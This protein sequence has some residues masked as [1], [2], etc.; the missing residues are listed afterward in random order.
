MPDVA[1][2]TIDV[3]LLGPLEVTRR[4]EAVPLGSAK[5]RV[6]LTVLAAHQGHW[7]SVE[8]LVDAAWGESAAAGARRSLQTHVSNLRG[9]LDPDRVGVLEGG[10]G[11][12]RLAAPPV[13]ETD[14]RRFEQLADAS[15]SRRLEAAID[16]WRGDPFSDVH[17]VGLGPIAVS[18][19]E[20]YLSVV[21]AWAAA[22]LRE[23]DP[24]RAVPRL[25]QLVEAHPLRESLWAALIRCL[26]A[27]GRNADALA[28]FRRLADHLAETGLEPSPGLRDLEE[29]VFLED[30]SLVVPG[31]DRFRL[32]TVDGSLH[33][34]AD[35]VEEVAE[36]L[37]R[38]RLVTLTGV[39][40]IGKTRL[41]LAAGRVRSGEAVFV[42][43]SPVDAEGVVEAFGAALGVDGRARTSLDA[44]TSALTGRPILLVV[45]NCEHV[46]AEVVR[47]LS[48][49]LAGSDDV[50][51]IATS[52]EPV[53]LPGE[54]VHRVRPLDTVDAVALFV[55]RARA[56][57]ANVD[58]DDPAIEGICTRLDGLPLAIELAA[59][60]SVHLPPSEIAKRL[61]DRFRLL[62]GGRRGDRRHR[63]L[64]AV[65]AWSHDLLEPDDQRALRVASVFVDGFDLA[66]FADVAS[67]G[68]IDALDRLGSL[69]DKSLVTH[70]DG[71]YGLLETVRLYGLAR[72][73]DVGETDALRAAH[74]QHFRDRNGSAES[75][76]VD[77]RID[78]IAV[79]RGNEHPDVANFRAALAWF[80]EH[81]DLESVGIVA[82]A[83]LLETGTFIRSEQ[84][85][86]YERLDVAEA[87][88]GRAQDLYLL[89]SAIS[90][91]GRGNWGG[92]ADYSR[93]FLAQSDEPILRATAAALLAQVLETMS[94]PGADAVVRSA[95][96]DLDGR[97]T[98]LVHVLRG[99]LLDGSLSR[100]EVADA[101]D[102]LEQLFEAREFIA[103]VD[104]PKAYLALGRSY[105]AEA[106][107]RRAVEVAREQD[108]QGGLHGG[109]I[110]AS[111]MWEQLVLAHV[112]AE[113]PH[114]AGRHLEAV[115]AF[116]RQFY[117]PLVDAEMLTAAAAIALRHDDAAHA[118]WLLAITGGEARTPG[119]LA[120]Y[121]AVRD[122]A[123]SRLT[124]EE[125]ASIRQ[126]A[127]R[128]T[129]QAALA[130]E[131]ERLRRALP[132]ESTTSR[133]E[134]P[135][136]TP[137]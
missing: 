8:R 47:V 99:R 75:W 3:R 96:D 59:A 119:G 121:I 107:A 85:R 117:D 116:N 93:R 111:Q 33:G 86:W 90:A 54:R 65:M 100:G 55:D 61:D 91:N 32:P 131:L 113:E 60:R 76:G 72:A 35:D 16:L 127:A 53:G 29:R 89:S 31:S 6:L 101:I 18:W 87:M 68:E 118:S 69:I 112:R 28:A 44:V 14:W 27:T 2:D 132:S 97:R 42:D 30:P 71:R 12:Y 73:G 17:V 67:M 98:D 41:A 19:T 15:D 129:P 62:S 74:A 80:D 115:E 102:E 130:A 22:C 25:E 37:D 10:P 64:E 78:W 21:E 79:A 81:G 103:L 1:T 134:D 110:A 58:P 34:R 45:D 56:R 52:R 123:R 135:G 11:G 105:D 136:G 4:G 57:G 51:V 23:G 38:S 95:I 82:I 9:A 70:A 126:R 114:R 109:S 125:I 13:V 5:Q 106:A 40:G 83:A 137:R 26:A 43:L 122:Q 63:T 7:V 20:R 120:L 46:L 92:Q 108:A 94:Q 104:L 39:G 50:R 66:A 124:P 84:G 24:G 36:L 48:R 128:S 77:D 88:S 49:V 133:S